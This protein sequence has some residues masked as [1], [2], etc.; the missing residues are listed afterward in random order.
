M[1]CNENA[2]KNQKVINAD[3]CHEL[4][5]KKEKQELAF[6]EN[7]DYTEWKKKVKEKF[8][9]LF[10]LNIIAKNTCPLDLSIEWKEDKGDYEL[11]RF[12]FQSEIGETVPC[13]LCVPK[14]D[15]KKYPVAITLQGHSTGF[16]NSIGVAK[17]DEDKDYLSRGAFALQAVKRGFVALAI[18]QRG[19]GERRPTKQNRGQKFNCQFASL[20]ALS[21]GRTILGER[22]WD[23][24]RAID[25]LSAFPVCDTENIVIT[26]N[27]GGGTVSYYAAAFDER[28]KTSVPS[29]AFCPY[30]DSIL[31]IWH[32]TCNYVPHAFEWFEM[33]DLACLIAPRKLAIVAGEKDDIFPICGVKKGYETVK[34]I[35]EKAGA[36]E[37]CSLTVTPKAHWWCEDIVWKIIENGFIK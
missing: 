9:E 31:D 27:S 8:T 2:G 4:L 13:Y 26:G 33:Q 24:H 5:L 14:R 18:E 36:P 12:T 1:D 21:L 30:A 19:M 28:I 15:K 37:N 10:G 29:C 20:V 6:S 23:V 16:H 22:I 11:I 35:Y 32:C 17:F 25:A 7:C 34:K 3:L